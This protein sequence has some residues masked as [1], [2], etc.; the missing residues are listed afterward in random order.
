MTQNPPNNPHFRHTEQFHTG[1]KNSF[2]T[3]SQGLP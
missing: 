3:E 1:E 2:S